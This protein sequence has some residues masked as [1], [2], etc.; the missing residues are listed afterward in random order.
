MNDYPLFAPDDSGVPTG[1]A[2]QPDYPKFTSPI[3][4]RW[5]AMQ[6]EQAPAEEARPR[7][8]DD[9]AGEVFSRLMG[10]GTD[11]RNKTADRINAL[12]GAWRVYADFARLQSGD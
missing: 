11:K 9:I 7:S 5:N 10:F 1:R 3:I 4:E 12:E 6:L 2:A 8:S